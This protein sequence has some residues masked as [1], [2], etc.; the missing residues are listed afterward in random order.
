MGGPIPEVNFKFHIMK[1][2]QFD[3]HTEILKGLST[4]KFSNMIEYTENEI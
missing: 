1:M 3:E 2:Q 4:E